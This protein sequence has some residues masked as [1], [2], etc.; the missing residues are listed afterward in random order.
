M[1]GMKLSHSATKVG[2]LSVLGPVTS[3][4]AHGVDSDKLWTV[5]RGVSGGSV[6]ARASIVV[7]I[8]LITAT[9]TDW[10]ISTE[11]R[12]EPIVGRQTT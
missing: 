1:G 7:D 12:N 3:V 8:L 4:L 6:N 9:P 10:L 2:T 11:Y 5:I